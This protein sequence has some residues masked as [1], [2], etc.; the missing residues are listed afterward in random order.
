MSKQKILAG[1]LIILV[2]SVITRVLGFVFRVYISNRLGA[3]GM[4]LYQLVLS[5]Y[6]LLVTFATSGITVAVSKMVAE[7][8]EANKYG[9]SR[10]VLRMAI[11]YSFVISITASVAL[12]IFAK[13][14]GVY[15]LHD[16]RTILSLCCLAPSLP[17]MAISACIKGYF[18]ALQDSLKPSSAQV[19]EQ[20]A[21]MG[22]AMGILYFWLPLGDA[23]GCAA[24]VLGMT[25][26]EIVS[27]G[28]I[29]ATYYATRKPE[30]IKK[31]RR[32]LREM[33]GITVPIQTSSTFH[34]LLRLFENLLII[35]A[36]RLFA[37]GDS[38]IAISAYGILKG[39]VLPLL[40]F[41]TSLLQALV[42]TLIPEV[43]GANVC[44]KKN[45]VARAVKKVLQLTLMMSVILVALFLIFPAQ[46]GEM[47]YHE[48]MVEG[49]LIKLCWI[50]PLMYLEMV[51]VGILNAI[52]EQ[53]APMRYNMID[54]VLRMGLIYLFVPKGGMNAF[55]FIMI[56][57]NLFTSLLNLR[58][59]LKVT[60]V[61]MM[62]KDWIIFPA[63]AAGCA[64]LFS[65]LLYSCFF[66]G[67]YSM[68]IGV[69]F[70][71]VITCFSYVILLFLLRCVTMK[72]IRWVK[73]AISSPKK[74]AGL[75]NIC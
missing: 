40:M 51:T 43:A 61:R 35:Y 42:T 25:I 12:F 44:G 37:G 9:S 6:M 73:S 29:I 19:I 14:L 33:I 15:I 32:I 21:K 71:C 5:L 7:Q 57:S 17:F 16:E 75:S 38:K 27:C 66:E 65:R 26:G 28:Y 8:R 2:A 68:P 56:L 31:Q 60:G 45:S 10:A 23:F 55:L 63:I 3:E 41:P 64:G 58:R 59:L 13:P 74:D 47:L 11:A 72:D 18:F 53:L 20:V 34:S 48:P 69:L 36:L 24:T 1:A 49:I 46:V 67:N 30:S 50:C 70:C 54:S 62:W 4:G 39:M 52:G 22:F